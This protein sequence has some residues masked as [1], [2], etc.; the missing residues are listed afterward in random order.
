MFRWNCGWE[1]PTRFREEITSGHSY[2]DICIPPVAIQRKWLSIAE[3][4]WFWVTSHLVYC[5]WT[6]VCQPV[7][8]DSVLR[9]SGVTWLAITTT[10][11]RRQT[12]T[13][14]N[15]ACSIK[16]QVL[17]VFWISTV[18]QFVTWLSVVVYFPDIWVRLVGPL[19]Q[20]ISVSRSSYVCSVSVNRCDLRIRHV[21]ATGSVR[22]DF[23]TWHVTLYQNRNNQLLLL[24]W[25]SNKTQQGS[26]KLFSG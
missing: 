7:R 9:S 16:R 12:R 24:L 23:A 5:A 13:T 3:S 25:V 21:G 4:W 6:G 26:G 14:V 19:S 20:V 2:C 1:H 10:V 8:T 17:H 11:T 22:L 15:V 18:M